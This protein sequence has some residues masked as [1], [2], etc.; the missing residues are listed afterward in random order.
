MAH[1]RLSHGLKIPDA[2]IGAMAITHALELYTYN[3]KD[4]RY[5]PGLRLYDLQ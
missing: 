2:L 5:M 3:Q 4:F 1:F